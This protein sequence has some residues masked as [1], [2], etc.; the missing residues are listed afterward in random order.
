[1]ECEISE[2]DGRL[3]LDAERAVLQRRGRDSFGVAASG[4][5]FV[6]GMRFMVSPLFGGKIR[7]LHGSSKGRSVPGTAGCVSA[8]E[9]TSWTI[10]CHLGVGGE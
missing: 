5:L 10:E 9:L 1:M 6:S 4:V 8:C 2:N 7:R 3:L